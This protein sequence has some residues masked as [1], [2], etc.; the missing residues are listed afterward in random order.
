MPAIFLINSIFF[1]KLN[2]Q[3]L[4]K[5][6]AHP[7]KLVSVKARL[8]MLHHFIEMIHQT[9]MRNIKQR[10]ISD[11][12]DYLFHGDELPQGI[13][14]DAENRM[15]DL[16]INALK[17]WRL[18]KLVHPDDL[19]NKNKLYDLFRAYKF[20]FNPN[21][22]IDALMT[23]QRQLSGNEFSDNYKK[24][25]EQVL[26]FYHQLTTTECL[27]LYGCFA[28]KDTT[29][30]MRTLSAAMQGQVIPSLP[31]LTQ[32]E[33]EVITKVYRILDCAMEAIRDELIKRHITTATYVRNLSAKQIKPG[34]RNLNAVTRILELYCDERVERNFLIEQLFNEIGA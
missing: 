23:L 22:L 25:S 30:L 32:G 11:V 18:H 33:Q 19:L 28:N 29:Y 34:R 16:V 14:I 9:V 12:H 26:I 20:W 21:R 17:E 10:G 27:E 8:S 1:Y 3:Q 7:E 15:S 13:A 31:I 4:F 5:Q 24:F 2:P 6:S